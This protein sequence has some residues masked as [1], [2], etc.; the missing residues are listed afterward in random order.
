MGEEADNIFESLE[1]TAEKK[2]YGA[3]KEKFE[4][5][6]IP[7]RNAIF[8]RAVFNQRIH[9]KG[10]S[11]DNF[12]TSLYTLSEHCEFEALREEMIRNRIVV[13]ILNSKLSRKLQLERDLKLADAVSQARRDE[14]V[15]QQ[16]AAVRNDDAGIQV[17][18]RR[19]ISKGQSLRKATNVA[20]VGVTST[21]KR[22]VSSKGGS[23]S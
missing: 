14:T 10:G 20:D 4:G 1:L 15:R 17:D 8:E 2:Q 7:R 9:K 18:E 5:Y 11:V 16:Q 12:I 22:R 19:N 13:G 3:V 23:V 21:P 6:F